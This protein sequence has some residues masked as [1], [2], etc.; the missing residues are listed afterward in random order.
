MPDHVPPE[1][2]ATV[3]ILGGGRG[4]RL[5]PLTRMRA[6]PAVP[7]G[8]KYR[9]IDIPISNAINS[10]TRR[11]YVLTQFNSHSLHRHIARTYRFDPFSRGFV[12]ILAAQ[13]TPATDRWFQ[14]T[15]DAVRQN[16]GIVAETSGDLVLILSGDHIYRMDYRELLAEHRR[17]G[18]EITVAVQPCSEQ[19]IAGFGA[20]RVAPDG[21]IVEFREKP[22]TAAERDGMQADPALLEAAGAD[23]AR[24]YLASMGLYVFDKRALFELLEGDATDFGGEVLP[25]AVGS[26]RVQAWLFDGYWRDIGTIGSFFETH[27]D[28]LEPRPRF[29][30]YDPRWPFFTH[31]RYL[32]G[33]RLA[34]T[35]S[36]RALVCEGATIERA[37]LCRAIA[38]VR[39]RIIEADLEDV[40]VMGADEYEV[41]GPPPGVPPIGIGPGTTIRRA[42]IDKNARIGAGCRLVNAQGLAHADGDGWAI[43][44]GIIV[45]AKNAVIPDGTTI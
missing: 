19:Q 5:D 11:I 3:L 21:R 26:R 23:R 17:S 13:Q 37:R 8:G 42:I 30:F 27:M 12:Q 33:S 14:G 25:A 32:P 6:K 41:G 24:P 43:R 34:E 44:D 29:S 1:L 20:V 38:G 7:V 39:S 2:D 31:P 18:A 35:R 28:L 4:T 10:G 9:L 40:L 22:K 36:E 15:A 16:L 45:V